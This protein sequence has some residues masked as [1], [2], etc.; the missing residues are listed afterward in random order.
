MHGKIEIITFLGGG[1]GRW[2][3]S[4]T[5]ETNLCTRRL[6]KNEEEERIIMAFRRNLTVPVLPAK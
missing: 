2:G 6:K 5:N 4:H 3:L 1:E